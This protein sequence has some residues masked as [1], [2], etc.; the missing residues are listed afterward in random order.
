[1]TIDE[2]LDRL[3]SIVETLA[4]S[5][6]AHDDHISA[7]SKQIEALITLTSKNTRDIEGLRKLQEEVSRQF[8][9][10]LNTIHPKQ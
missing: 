4:A 10:Y 8:Q 3:T 5:V 2:R 6:V 9:A 7:N 1:M